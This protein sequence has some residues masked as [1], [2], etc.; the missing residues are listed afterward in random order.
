V[1]LTILG[2]AKM[3]RSMSAVA[4]FLVLAHAPMALAGGRIIIPVTQN[5]TAVNVGNQSQQAGG[6]GNTAQ[7]GVLQQD[8]SQSQNVNIFVPESFRGKIQ[9]RDGAQGQG[10]GNQGFDRGEGRGNGHGYGHDRENEHRD[11]EGR[12]RGERDRD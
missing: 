5:Q 7:T 12:G 1:N 9:V 8:I 10:N 3:I 11:H 2:G 6:G 4:T